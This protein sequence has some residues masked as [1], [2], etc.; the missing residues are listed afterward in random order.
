MTERPILFR[1]EMVQAILAGRKTMTRRVR[2]T[3]PR[4]WPCPYGQPG[5][6]LWVRETWGR[7]GHPERIVYRENPADDYQWDA[8]KP[9]QGDFR[10]RPSI[11]MPRRASRITLEIV[12]VRVERVQDISEEDAI[13]EGCSAEKE[14]TRDW[15]E[16]YDP[17]MRDRYGNAAHQMVSKEVSPEPPPRWLE[18]RTRKGSTGFNISAVEN[19]KILWD[20]LNDKRG[21]G[22]DVNPWVWALLFRRIAP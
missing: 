1:A 13:A 3:E 20:S 6:R 11:F 22:W 8:G 10:W 14:T 7:V 15:W 5:D 21:Y 9:S 12:G 18:V 17:D 19:Y 16:G 2:M 4:T